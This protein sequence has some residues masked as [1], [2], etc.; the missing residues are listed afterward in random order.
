MDVS[1][2]NNIP[3]KANFELCNLRTHYSS[4]V[5]PALLRVFKNHIPIS[6]KILKTYRDNLYK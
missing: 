6:R 2:V 3:Q 5:S 4:A 1:P